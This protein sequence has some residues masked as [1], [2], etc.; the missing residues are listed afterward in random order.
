MK[1]TK[2]ITKKQTEEFR[3]GYEGDV[4]RRFSES[5]ERVYTAPEA[6]AETLLY[7]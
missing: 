5:P 7:F 4:Q 2:I 3:S 6:E 1:E